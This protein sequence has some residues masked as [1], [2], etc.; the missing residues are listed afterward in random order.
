MS[1]QKRQKANQLGRL[2]PAGL[3]ASAGWL[4]AHD[5]RS[6]LLAHYVNS[7]RLESPARGVYRVPG[8]PLKWQSVVA[9]LQLIEGSWSHVGGHTAL[10]QR[11]FGHYA[12]LSGVETID[13][14]GPDNLPH[15]VN[16]LGVPAKFVQ[17]R[18]AAFG[19]LRVRR[20]REGALRRFE[21]DTPIGA[22][23]LGSFG[24]VEIKWGNW[25]W[26]LIFSSEERAILE[27]LEGVP[28]RESIYEVWVLL[29]GLV[30][31]RPL[32]VST[33]LRACKS[34]K[35]RRL[36]LAMADRQ[37][38]AWFKHLDLTGLDLGKG[39]RALFPGGKLDAKG[40]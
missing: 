23:E 14:Y 34:I 13:L 39:K 36:F 21:A 30:N 7:H 22:D 10:V 1:E 31:L 3:V 4:D 35:A 38:H 37:H 29:Q 5:Y 19:S 27:M 40:S 33:L 15:W 26:P 6:N 32:R 2:L 8:P 9:S 28:E 18:D 20:D 25:D 12:Q 16:K 17:R 24:L 11:G